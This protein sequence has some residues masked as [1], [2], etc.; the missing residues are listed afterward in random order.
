MIRKFVI[1]FL[2]TAFCLSPSYAQK[3]KP[4]RTPKPYVVVA[5][6]TPEEKLFEQLLPSTAKVM[7][8][9]SVVVDKATFLSHLPISN[10]MGSIARKGNEV[11][12]TN[13]FGNTQIIA[14]GDTLQGRH[15]YMSHYYG[16]SWTEKKMLKELPQ[17]M[18][19][20]PFLMPD[21]VT[22]FFSAEGDGTIGGRD[23]FRTTYD[24]DNARFYDATNI[25]MPYNSKFNDYLLVISDM[26]NIGFL[27]SD[28]FQ[29]EDKVCIYTFEP[30]S[31]RETFSEN[32]DKET[33]TRFARIGNIKE[34][35]SFGNRKSAL[36]RRDE[37][38]ARM[39]NKIADKQIDFIVND[40]TTYTSL[41]DF[42][43]SN[44]K[45]IYQ[46][47]MHMKS[48]LIHINE[49]IEETRSR[50]AEATHSKKYELGRQIVKL[51]KEALALDAD[52]KIKEK[53]LR[54][55]ENK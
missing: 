22:M 19:D 34:T 33:L 4:K 8:I 38:I 11:C 25:G 49:I 13:E 43:S 55:I 21:G 31:Q 28:R 35:W 45:S 47:I 30:T 15:L 51:E 46:N 1:L 7:F 24:A 27:V 52:I 23:I 14:S 6:K 18:A 5:E 10:E 16:N 9:D 37:L 32:I 2:A 39:T 3:R 17:A 50:Y 48:T 53:Q 29:Q 54:N 40:N 42:Q 36:K 26:D 44:G 12:Y 41:S 20:Y